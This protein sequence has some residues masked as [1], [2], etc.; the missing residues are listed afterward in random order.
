MGFMIRWDVDKILA[1]LRACN[2]QVNSHY[3]DGFSAWKCKQDLLTIKYALDEMLESCPSFGFMETN[4]H[5]EQQK[6]KVWRA[7]NDKV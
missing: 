3:N 2:A 4:F 6:K 7:L 5:D 1:D